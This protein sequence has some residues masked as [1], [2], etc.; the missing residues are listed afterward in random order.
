MNIKKN[1]ISAFACAA[2][3]FG[4]I[5]VVQADDYTA[6]QLADARQMLEQ[7]QPGRAASSLEKA[8]PALVASNDFWSASRGYFQLAVARGRQN[9]NR[10]ACAALSKSVDYY[11]KALVRDNLSLDYFGDMASDGTEGSDGLREVSA[12]LGCSWSAASASAR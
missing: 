1:G 4:C 10:A 3:V 7:G 12:R 8:L 6:Q 5:N 9:Q 11:R 2:L